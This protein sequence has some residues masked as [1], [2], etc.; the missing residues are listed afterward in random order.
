MPATLL[1]NTLPTCRRSLILPGDSSY[2]STVPSLLQSTTSIT[3]RLVMASV[4]VV[5]RKILVRLISSIHIM[6]QFL[7]EEKSNG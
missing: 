4:F 6:V 7:F 1:K 3:R 2:Q 5:R